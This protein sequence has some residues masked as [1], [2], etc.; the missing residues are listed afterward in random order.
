M[1][2]ATRWVVFVVLLG[3]NTWRVFGQEQTK[4]DK[5]LPPGAVLKMG[6]PGRLSDFPCMTLSG[7]GKLL[8]TGYLSPPFRVW[9]VATGKE[10]DNFAGPKQRVE[11]VALSPCG[12]YLACGANHGTVGM[13]ELATQKELLLAEAHKGKRES[14]ASA[15]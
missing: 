3:V 13:Y 1:R 6:V 12:K 14:S 10:V 15:V 8:A 9:D 2:A 5:T 11:A 4:A 7:D